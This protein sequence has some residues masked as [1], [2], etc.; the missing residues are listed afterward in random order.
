MQRYFWIIWATVLILL[1]GLQFT[2]AAETAATTGAAATTVVQASTVNQTPTTYSNPRVYPASNAYLTRQQIRQ[3][4][5]LM[6][7]NRPG[8]FYGNTVRRIYYRRM[9]R[10]R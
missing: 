5:L 1:S 2:S 3:M 8:H 4:P 9:A 6:R 10:G 7:P